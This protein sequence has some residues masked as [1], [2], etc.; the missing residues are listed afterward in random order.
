M[1]LAEIRKEIDEIDQALVELLEKRMDCVSQ[2]L[3][4]KKTSGQE[5]TD[6]E[7]E[8]EVLARVSELVKQEDYRETIQATFAD[9]MKESRKYQQSKLS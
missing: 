6:K 3:A 1:K 8:A 9:I 4:A 2:V 7:R 5:V